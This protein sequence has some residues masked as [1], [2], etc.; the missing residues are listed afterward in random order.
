[1]KS[2]L[3][4]VFFL[5]FFLNEKGFTYP[6][7]S[8]NIP[9]EEYQAKSSSEKYEIINP[10]LLS[11]YCEQDQE[12]YYIKSYF[13]AYESSNGVQ[14]LLEELY[15]YSHRANI[16]INSTDFFDFIIRVLHQAK[17]H[18]KIS[19]SNV[20]FAVINYNHLLYRKGFNEACNYLTNE[21]D[22]SINNL[23]ADV[24]SFF[25]LINSSKC[26]ESANNFNESIFFLMKGLELSKRLPAP[27]NIL[28]KGHIYKFLSA[29][30][31]S[32]KDYEM[33]LYYANL[34][35]NTFLPEFKN[36]IGTGVGYEFKALSTYKLTNN[37][38]EALTYFEKAQDI[39]TQKNNISRFHYVEKLKAELFL[40]T[41]PDLALLH[42]FNFL[43]YFETN[44]R[45]VHF[46]SGWLFVHEIM[47]KH[48]LKVIKASNDRLISTQQI[49]EKLTSLIKGEELK[50]KFLV[51]EALIEYYADHNKTDSLIK[52]NQLQN[53]FEKQRNLI[54]QEQTKENLKLYLTNYQKE[55]EL[56]NLNLLNQE[57]SYKNKLLSSLICIVVITL[58]FYFFY[59]RKQKQILL[60]QLKL[61]ETE[62]NKLKTE[63]KLK[64]ELILKKE[65]AEK[66]LKLAYDNELKSK[67]LLKLKLQQK[68][69]QVESAQ[70]EKQS[71][72]NLLNE[73]V[74]ALKDESVNDAS[75]LLKKLK[76]DEIIKK[77]NNS[78]K[79]VFE[80]ISPNFMQQLN[81]INAN[82]T[83]Q[84]ILYCV[85]IRQKYS[86]KQ[87]ADFLSISPKSVNQHKYR[88]KKKLVISKEENINTFIANIK[89]E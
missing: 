73:V 12:E 58:I 19:N 84:D 56:A 5:I 72:I 48:N 6:D 45:K 88:L 44:N 78:L 38:E 40:E 85:L 20:I 49:I 65:Q 63:Q 86:T 32:L 55:Q 7:C 53:K 47:Q 1:M 50:N 10:Y 25:Y 75:H 87:I 27:E 39:Y 35:I 89:S 66:M 70:L 34:C 16:D 80:S 69:N 9:F 62:H 30:Y 83:E 60:A 51:T 57:Q 28:R 82:L 46:T 77:H 52:Y 8:S 74:S 4:L 17:V 43:D 21:V 2:R 3:I 79:E 11:A 41:N 61:K 15:R 24:Y 29:R 67:E 37:I 31:Y 18:F 22:A 59:K 26:A 54:T 76:T 71:S 68:Q 33:S 81:K 14:D 13:K 36:K 23:P 64:E 42:I